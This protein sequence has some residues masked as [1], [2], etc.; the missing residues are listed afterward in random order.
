[1][2]E[3][4]EPQDLHSCNLAR[5]ILTSADREPLRE[6][7][8]H[9]PERDATRVIPLLVDLQVTPLLDALDADLARCMGSKS[10]PEQKHDLLDRHEVLLSRVKVSLEYD[11]RAL[12]ADTHAAPR[13]RLVRLSAIIRAE[14][15]LGQAVDTARSCRRSLSL[16]NRIDPSRTLL[17]TPSWEREARS[18]ASGS[19]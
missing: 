8:L 16:P 18:G 19:P 14:R 1:M 3:A 5:M 2:P 4:G 17:G 11:G 13:D 6:A 9:L 12:D 15:R 10:T 7:L